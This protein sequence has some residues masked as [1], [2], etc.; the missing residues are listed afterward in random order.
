MAGCL[1]G[2]LIAL[3]EEV[4]TAIAHITSLTIEIGAFDA[5]AT[6][7]GHTIG[8]FGTL[9]AVVPRDEEVIPAVVLEDEGCFDGVRS[10]KVGRR[11][12]GGIGIHRKGVLCLRIREIV[13][14]GD[15]AGLF[16]L[17]DM[18]RRV[19]AGQL[20]AV[21][22]R[23]PHEP[24]LILIVD[25]EVGVDGVPVVAA[26]TGRD[27]AAHVIPE[28][29]GQ[30]TGGEESDGRTVASEGGTAVG[31]PPAVVPFDD[32]RRPD[33]MGE[34]GNGVVGPL[35]DDGHDG[36]RLHRPGLAVLGGHVLNTHACGKDMPGAVFVGHHGVVDH[37]CVGLEVF[38]LEAVR[39]P[40]CRHRHNKG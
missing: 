33:V 10:G 26:F 38:L 1:E 30:G 11:V 27:D 23:T 8:A 17:G 36:S 19:E 20:D 4:S 6:A 22:E 31:E 24:G 5:L 39:L 2:L 12:L 35:G 21:P 32:I 15:G 37:R 14:A 40:C 18:H 34:A 25:D 3:D 7:Y 28:A 9:T 29:K 16:A 13:T